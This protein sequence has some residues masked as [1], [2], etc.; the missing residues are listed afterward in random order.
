MAFSVVDETRV[1]C[2]SIQEGKDTFRIYYRVLVVDEIFLLHVLYCISA[3]SN[4][5]LHCSNECCTYLFLW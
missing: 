2:D 1:E 3:S 5:L 4:F